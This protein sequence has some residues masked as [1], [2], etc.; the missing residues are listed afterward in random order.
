MSAG[1]RFLL[2]LTAFAALLLVGGLVDAITDSSRAAL[3]VAGVAAGLIAGLLGARQMP[4]V[5]ELTDWFALTDP[6]VE[7]AG[8]RARGATASRI[9]R[10][11]LA[12]VVVVAVMRFLLPPIEPFPT[13]FG[14]A[15]LIAILTAILIRSHRP[16]SRIPQP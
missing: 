16:S 6:K 2:T 14:S 9:L 12:A 4:P 13:T 15:F 8:A 10:G 5:G 1:R 11:L 7:R 3:A